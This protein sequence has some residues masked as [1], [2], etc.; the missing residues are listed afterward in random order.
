MLNNLQLFIPNPD[1]RWW[2]FWKPREVLTVLGAQALTNDELLLAE[3]ADDEV[4]LFGHICCY[5]GEQE[6]HIDLTA[7]M[8]P[9]SFEEACVLALRAFEGSLNKILK[10]EAK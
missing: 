5:L 4:V 1:R 6:I 3:E 9:R 2:Q 7:D 8:E 10:G